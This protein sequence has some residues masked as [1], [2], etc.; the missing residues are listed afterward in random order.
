MRF[1]N[2]F[3]I[4]EEVVQAILADRYSHEG[5]ISV[6]TLLLPPR[7]RILRKRHR[8]EIEE[9][10]ADRLWSLYGQVVH[11]VLER[12]DDW[13]AFHEE[14]LYV[15]VAGWRLTGQTDLFKRRSTGEHVL[16]D[17]KFTSVFTADKDKPEWVS[18][19]NIYAWMW[20]K[21]GFP[22]DRAQ[23]VLLFRD[24]RKR[25]FERSQGNY[26]PPVKLVDVPLWTDEAAEQFVTDL[27]ERHR[28]FED[29]PD[30]MLPL[31]T[32]EEQWA[33]NEGWAV[34]KIGRKT[35]IRVLDNELEASRLCHELSSAKK[36]EFYVQ[37][38]RPEPVRCLYFCNV[39]AF[40][41]FGRELQPAG[42]GDE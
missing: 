24:W 28:V 17:Y 40:C 15:E 42:E 1:T 33:R 38:R 16:R 35:A 12:S 9:D 21:H 10:V 20:R 7:I 5:D 4:P 25:E 31:C 18:Q 36:G 3:D 23:I 19:V 2:R 29:F 6:T 11:G 34:M 22:V 41:D 26:P 13:E 27:I 8:E 39:K 30:H 14:R 37:Y 32:P